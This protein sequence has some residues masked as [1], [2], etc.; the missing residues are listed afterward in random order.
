MLKNTIISVIT[1]TKNDHHGLAA[2][3]ASVCSQKLSIEIEHIIV[4]GGSSVRTRSVLGDYIKNKNVKYISEGD[5]GIS[6][7]FNIGVKAASGVYVNF[8]NS[9]DTYV[10]DNTLNMVIFELN[11]RYC[12]ISTAFLCITNTGIKFTNFIDWAD[13]LNCD[14][15]NSIGFIRE[16]ISKSQVAHQA[17]FILR[18][19]LLK[20]GKFDT[21]LK[22]RMDFDFFIRYN[23]VF[24]LAFVPKVVTIYQ[25]NGISS[26]LKN[27]LMFKLE[28]RISIKKNF[29]SVLYEF[30]FWVT[31]PLYLGRKLLSAIFY[32]YKDK[33][34]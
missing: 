22:L 21:N 18:E 15:K 19:N 30:F 26:K 10:D 3:V 25:T 2:T 8:L 20:I 33:L 6:D 34:S 24:A 5:K 14:K 29:N 27:R 23:L 7:A 11:K 28:E 4:D 13:K 17:T 32:L 31:L 1:I 12:G 9:G 16:L